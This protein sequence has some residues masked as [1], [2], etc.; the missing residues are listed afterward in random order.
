MVGLTCAENKWGKCSSVFLPSGQPDLF[1]RM[2]NTVWIP[3]SLKC[4]KQQNNDYIVECSRRKGD[5]L[6]RDGGLML[7]FGGAYSSRQD[8]A[9]N[10]NERLKDHKPYTIAC[11]NSRGGV[12]KMFVNDKKVR[13]LKDNTKQKT[14]GQNNY[15]SGPCSTTWGDRCPLVEMKANALDQPVYNITMDKNDTVAYV[16]TGGVTCKQPPAD[17]KSNTLSCNIPVGESLEICNNSWLG[18]CMRYYNPAEKGAAQRSIQLTCPNNLK[19]Q[20]GQSYYYD[21]IEGYKC[22]S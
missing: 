19:F 8:V 6:P 12:Y 1:L 3:D 5:E 17:A 9:I 15:T 20:K 14:P 22:D 7:Q 16:I 18:Q 2:D 10:I 4:A 13:C 11:S 21:N